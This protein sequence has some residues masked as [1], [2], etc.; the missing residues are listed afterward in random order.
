MRGLG[1]GGRSMG[2]WWMGEGENFAGVG[3]GG[4]GV[5]GFLGSIWW[6]LMV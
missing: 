6:E 3:G 2:F 4:L 5:D 1:V